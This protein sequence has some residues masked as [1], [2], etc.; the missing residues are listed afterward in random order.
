[1]SISLILCLLLFCKRLT[2]EI[3]HV[4]LGIILLSMAARHVCRH[5]GRLKYKRRSVRIMDLVMLIAM[6]VVFFSGMLLH[7]L[8][9]SLVILILHKMASVILVIGMIVHV[10]QHRSS[11]S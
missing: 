4:I 10:I 2:G 7:P 9:G 3:C 11:V 8:Q 6:A 5:I 1:M